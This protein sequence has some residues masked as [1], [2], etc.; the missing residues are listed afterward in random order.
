VRRRAFTLV[1]LLVVI[2]IIAILIAL[3]LPA[4][5]MT[6]ESGRRTQCQSNLKQ[7]GDAIQGIRAVRR[8]LPPLAA[9]CAA[10]VYHH[11]NHPEDY[12]FT[13]AE[14][15]VVWVVKALDRVV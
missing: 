13:P 5:Q 1:E 2:V 9:R 4:V 14:F 11:D 15:K 10:P 12:C 7:L 8:V 6:R 3:L